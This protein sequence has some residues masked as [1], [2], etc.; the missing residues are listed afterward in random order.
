MMMIIIITTIKRE[1]IRREKDGRRG[2]VKRREGGEGVAQA[3]APGSASEESNGRSSRSG[4]VT[5]N[6]RTG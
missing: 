1:G 6:L 2:E 5:S 3:S 4:I